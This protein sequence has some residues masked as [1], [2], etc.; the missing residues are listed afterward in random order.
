MVTHP[1][2]LLDDF[3]Q[4]LRRAGR[5]GPS[6]PISHEAQSAPHRPHALP[7]QRCAVYVFSLSAAYGSRCAAGANR[8]LK[9]GKVGS[10]SNARFQFQHYNPGAAPSTL[11]ASLIEGYILWPYLGLNQI[12]KAAV[13]DWIRENTDRDNFYLL[14]GDQPLLGELERYLRGRLGPVFEG[15]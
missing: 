2:S 9:V 6:A 1:H 7:P 14:D 10:K 5:P 15:G 12:T 11:A 3:V 8:A 4:A 13:G